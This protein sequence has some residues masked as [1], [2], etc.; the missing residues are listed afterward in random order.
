MTKI[1]LNDLAD[2]QNENTA[3][4]T[5]NNN[6]AAIE[7]AS[8]TF[9]SRDG[10]SPNTMESSLDM[11]SNR[12]INLPSPVGAT[13][14]VRLT[15]LDTLTTVGGTFTPLPA[16]GTTNQVLKKNSATNY[17]VGWGNGVGV[18]SVALSMP[19]DFT[20]TGSP[21]TTTGTLG[22]TL[23]NAATGT[24]GFVRA[25]SPALVTPAL[26]TPS[27]AVLTNATGLPLS[28]LTNQGAFT[29]VGNNTSGSA[30]PTAVDIA[31][32]TTKG[33]PAGT[34]YVMLSD[35][36]ASGAWKKATVS[37]V[38]ASTG[39]ASI[40]G[41]TGVF[42]LGAGL[43]NVVNDIQPASGSII[44]SAFGSYAAATVLTVAIPADDTIPQNTE[45]TQIIS[46]SY[47]PRLSTSTLYCIFRGNIAPASLENIIAAIFQGGS[48]NAISS[49]MVTAAAA[50][51]RTHISVEGFYA[52]GSTSAQ[53]ITVRVGAGSGNCTVNGTGGT[54][55]LGGSSLATLH[56]YEI[57]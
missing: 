20:V 51:N 28:G 32:L 46:V 19:A 57:K 53:T 34:D 36:A 6:N 44:G 23:A 11:N 3:V 9:L 37:S 18:T 7:T 4:L 56:V 27:A 13:E 8:D 1:L 47:T 55:I 54:R 25:T 14:P 10:T 41:N 50:N 45:G 24:G 49:G 42:T 39:V 31:A 12:V 38:A 35:Q 2:L 43:T 40:A 21:I 17:D 22:V 26:G 16:G 29:F 33:T 30:A 48:A 5:I 15:D 52:P